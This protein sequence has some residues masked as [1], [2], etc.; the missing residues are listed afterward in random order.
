M[1]TR[2]IAILLHNPETTLGGAGS[3][4]VTPLETCI[5]LLVD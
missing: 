1:D 3:T 2:G 4:L 5:S